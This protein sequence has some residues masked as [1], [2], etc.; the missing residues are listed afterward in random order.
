[1]TF[2][3]SKEWKNI[4]FFFFFMLP[5][6]PL[7]VV[8][9]WR[10]SASAM[11]PVTDGMSL[12]PTTYGRDWPVTFY[13]I[14]WCSEIQ[15]KMI[16]RVKRESESR[17]T[18][19]SSSVELRSLLLSCSLLRGRVARFPSPDLAPKTTPKPFPGAISVSVSILASIA[20]NGRHK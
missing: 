15:E 9:L 5:G 12:F 18:E 20:A 1:M 2:I 6:V 13:R 16:L 8:A 7:A 11:L 4:Y 10:T 14:K 3:R 19:K 17:K